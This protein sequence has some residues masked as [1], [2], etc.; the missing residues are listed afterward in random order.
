MQ[1]RDKLFYNGQT[2]YVKANPLTS[3]FELMGDDCPVFERERE[4]HYRVYSGTWEIENDR[5]FLIDFNGFIAEDIQVSIDFLFPE[6][7][8]VFA[9]W[10]TGEIDIPQGRFRDDGIRGSRVHEKYLFL[11]F[12]K[13]VIVGSRIEETK[14]FDSENLYSAEDMK[15]S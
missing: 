11:R 15:I 4:C 3:L 14:N 1:P 5:L 6:Q 8:K 13:G 2:F 10:F 9:E 7:K 12:E